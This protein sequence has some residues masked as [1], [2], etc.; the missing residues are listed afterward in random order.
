MFTVRNILVLLFLASIF[1]PGIYQAILEID[2][3]SAPQALDLF[4]ETPGEMHLRRFEK[5]L[6]SRSAPAIKVRPW[7]QY[8]QFLFLRNAGDKAVAGIDDWMFYKPGVTYLVES[9]PPSPS[10]NH[11]L[12][13]ALHAIISFREQLARRGIGLVVMPVPEKASI[14]PDMLAPTI[15]AGDLPLATHTME[16]LERLKNSGVEAIDLFQAFAETRNSKASHHTLYLPQDTHWSPEGMRVAAA[17][18]AEY[19]MGNGMA[20]KGSVQFGTKA[21]V[22]RRA[23]DVL[24]MM[25][26]PQLEERLPKDEI[27]CTQVLNAEDGTPYRDDA[28]SEILVLGDS[29]LRIYERDEPGSAGFIAHLARELSQPLASIVSDG[30]ASTLVRQELSRKPELL[31]NKKLVVWEF[32]ERDIRFGTEGWQ[33]VRIRFPETTGQ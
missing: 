7:M 12:D 27:E 5:S 26:V 31:I 30:G 14:Y 4:R 22:L 9:L 21:V 11:G 6:E 20:K 2:A 8:F 17:K 29:F 28:Q 19:L 13:S 1:M 15:R 16:F 25:G 24:R 33:D 23:G 10:G 18:T 32:V 3:G